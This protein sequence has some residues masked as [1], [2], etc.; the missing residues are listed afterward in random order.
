MS[1]LFKK[2]DDGQSPRQENFVSYFCHALCSLLDFLTLEDGT[3]KLSQNVSNKLPLYGAQHLRRARIPHKEMAMQGLVW[4]RM[5]RLGVAP[6][7]PACCGSAWSG[8]AWLR[9]V[10]LVVAPH[11]LAWCGSAWSGLAFHVRISDDLTYLSSNFK[12]KSSS[13]V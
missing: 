11:G 7:G 8:L 6:H 3:N 12:E 4:L 9:M 2:S 1:C 13:C 5:V 10:R